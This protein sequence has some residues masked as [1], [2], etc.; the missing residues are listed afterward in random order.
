MILYTCKGFE[1]QCHVDVSFGKFDRNVQLQLY[2]E[3]AKFAF[4]NITPA[5][6][7]KMDNNDEENDTQ[8]V[9]S[10]Y[11]DLTTYS[12]DRIIVT[13]VR[14]DAQSQYRSNKPKHLYDILN[15]FS[16][17]NRKRKND[18]E[19]DKC[20][21]SSSS[22]NIVELRSQENESCYVKIDRTL[23]NISNDQLCS[24]LLS[25]KR[26]KQKEYDC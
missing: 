22:A 3:N 16:E 25:E 26:R 4:L 11:S 12:H 23:S 19:Y 13:K 6:C 5:V 10:T 24:Y 9:T 14:K 7:F 1:L 8:S 20:P 15:E 18:G 21:S 17:F 2:N